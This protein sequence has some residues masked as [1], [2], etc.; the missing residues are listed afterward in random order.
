M[1]GMF[2]YVFAVELDNHHSAAPASQEGHPFKFWASH[3]HGSADSEADATIGFHRHVSEMPTS[4]LR[5]SVVILETLATPA[6]AKTNSWG[7][8]PVVIQNVLSC[9]SSMFSGRWFR[10]EHVVSTIFPPLSLR[11]RSLMLV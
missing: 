8:I 6:T 10:S 2:S 3:S 5:H 4:P 1:C 7:Y 11:A 9:P